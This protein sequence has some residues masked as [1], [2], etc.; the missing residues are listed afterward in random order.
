[1]Q[2]SINFEGTKKVSSNPYDSPNNALAA[3]FNSVCFQKKDNIFISCEK[4]TPLLKEILFLVKKSGLDSGRI[5]VPSIN[6]ANLLYPGY[7]IKH[8]LDKENIAC[9]GNV[10]LIDNFK[11]DNIRE[12]LHFKSDFTLK[13]TIE[14]M[15]FYSNN[16]IANQL[17]L[18]IGAD[19]NGADIEKSSAFYKKYLAENKINANVIEGS[20]ISRENKI[21]G[22]EMIKILKKFKPYYLLM[23]K[24][25]NGNFYKTGTLA[26]VKNLCGF[27]LDKEDKIFLYSIFFNNSL[28]N[29]FDE[30]F[31]LKQKIRKNL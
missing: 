14:K 10:L 20:G 15:L 9:T 22:E 6:D 11:P 5:P 23:K 30:F 1:M 17:F 29:P 28:K 27:F 3:N 16:F 8:F 31:I 2:K 4:E 26:G 7:L 25:G 21:S 12:I 24:D 18:C 13:D 19:E